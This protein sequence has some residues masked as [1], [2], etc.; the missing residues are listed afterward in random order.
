MG[1]IF[2]GSEVIELGIGFEKDSI[3]F[4]QGMKKAVPEYDHKVIVG[5]D[6]DRIKEALG[7]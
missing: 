5:F 2:S 3:F 7:L 6:K 1:N 4:Y